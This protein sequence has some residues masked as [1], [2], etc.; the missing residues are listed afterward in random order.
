MGAALAFPNRIAFVCVSVHKNTSVISPGRIA[1]IMA[2]LTFEHESDAFVPVLAGPVF[3]PNQFQSISW[4]KIHL[5]V[6]CLSNMGYGFG[7]HV[8]AAGI[9]L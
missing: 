4:I 9:L 1:S 6:S 7:V 8:C 5:T 2:N 3:I